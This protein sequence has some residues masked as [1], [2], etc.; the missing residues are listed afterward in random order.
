MGLQYRLRVS[1]TLAVNAGAAWVD[2][3]Y[4][5]D[6]PMEDGLREGGLQQM[7]S[8]KIRKMYRRT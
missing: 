6:I 4:D 7:L 2:H 1:Q 5:K 8:R 3:R